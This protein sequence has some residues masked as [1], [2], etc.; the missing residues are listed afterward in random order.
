MNFN[1][2]QS[3]PPPSA[4]ERDPV[5]SNFQATCRL[6]PDAAPWEEKNRLSML[7]FRMFA[8][9]GFQADPPAERNVGPV[10]TD[11]S[12]PGRKSRKPGSVA[13][14]WW[15]SNVHSETS[16]KSSDQ[17]R[18]QF[19]AAAPAASASRATTGAMATSRMRM[20]IA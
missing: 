11:K 20:T 7:K 12:E 10:Q 16:L 5:G 18:V 14:L 9:V 4:T 13:E 6:I 17:R 1:W 19:S 3:V 2:N 15:E 8:V